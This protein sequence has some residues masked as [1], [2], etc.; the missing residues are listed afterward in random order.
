MST[1]SGDIKI[2]ANFEVNVGKP[3][4]PRVTATTI[5]N[6]N[7]I[8]FKYKGMQVYVEE[9]SSSY[10]L[11]N[12][13]VTWVLSGSKEFID[14]K[15]TNYISPHVVID[16]TTNGALLIASLAAVK[17]L[18]PGGIALSATN[19]V[20]VALMPGIYDLGSSTLLADTQ[21]V[22]I[23][24]LT[25][26]AD[27]VIIR[28]TSTT[29]RQTA[30]DVRFKN[31][32][33][34]SS[35]LGFYAYNPT[36][37][38]TT[39][40][41]MDNVSFY[42]TNGGSTNPAGLTHAGVYNNIKVVQIT[43]PNSREDAFGGTG[44]TASGTFTNC[45]ITCGNNTTT[46]SFGGGTGSQSPGI[47]NN[48]TTNSF[49]LDNGSFGS[50]STS[51]GTYTNCNTYSS[52][53]NNISFGGQGYSSGVSSGVYINCNSYATYG[54]NNS[55]GGGGISSGTYTNCTANN[56]FGPC[57]SFGGTGTSNGVYNSCISNSG[58]GYNYSFGGN[59]VA[60]SGRY[61]NCI[62]NSTTGQ[63]SSFGGSS[64]SG[65]TSG[66]FSNCSTNTTTGV[67]VSF[68][69]GSNTSAYGTFISCTPTSSS[70]IVNS[71][72]GA[73]GT[74]SGGFYQVIMM[75]QFTA[76]FTGYIANSI[77]SAIGTNQTGMTDIRTS[78][79]VYNCTIK[80]TGTGKSIDSIVASQTPSIAHS[81]FN[82]SF[83]TNVT[84]GLTTNYNIIDPLI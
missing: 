61:I 18:T 1:P 49:F 5:V 80:G 17:L 25:S 57:A 78:A 79:K 31:I 53:N 58:A 50:G 67:N 28:S 62:S 2:S 30:N 39:N 37:T 21:Y 81:R 56:A 14:S 71:F 40:T 60:A 52:N 55:F 77:V 59:G 12:D 27:S 20:Q 34:E 4:D 3:A 66:Y 33:L 41:I 47:F 46:L 6:R 69:G 36:G 65:T 44:S 19:R 22:D 64:P 45:T 54:G 16:Y 11:Q 51:N 38:S 42:L 24:G 83:G 73:G 43:G 9:T 15:G 75:G 8:T 72:G 48:I 74:A 13:L 70:G 82:L 32:R 35:V 26:D 76:T 29:L 84:N 10:T 63:N 68:G 7:N 23:V